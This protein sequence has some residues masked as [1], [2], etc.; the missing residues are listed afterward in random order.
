MSVDE[1]LDPIADQ[2]AGFFHHHVGDP[3][4][5]VAEVA[6]TSGHAGFSYS[7]ELRSNGESTPYFLRLPPSGVRLRGTADV[8]R[9]VCALR[10]LDGTAAPHA[11][12]IW[13]G[14][15]ER[16]FGT[17]YFITEWV[18]GTTFDADERV[19]ALSARELQRVARQAVEGLV[20]MREAPWRTACQYLGEPLDLR[21]RITHWDRFLERAAERDALLGEVPAVRAA[22]LASVPRNV[23]LGLCH[24]DYQFGNLMFGPDR[25]LR[26]IIDWELCSVGPSLRDLGWLVA[27]N[28]APAWEPSVRPMA[29]RLSAGEILS[30]WPDEVDATD[31]PWFEAFALYEYAVISGFNLM[32][33]RRGKRPDPTWEWR[34]RSAPA[35]LGRALELLD[36]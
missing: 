3:D 31:L 10:A 26:A 32:L 24:G 11:R 2:L 33:H 36:G 19:D 18:V 34:S 20:A 17:P 1:R 25:D 7:F 30:H 6:P 16:W 15:D 12:V 21:E 35:N 27:F 8:L 22:L 29:R 4:A 13:S 14:D 5:T 28:D 23:H 9:Q